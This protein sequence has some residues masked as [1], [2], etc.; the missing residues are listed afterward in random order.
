MNRRLLVFVITC[1]LSI[2]CAA[3]NGFLILSQDT[4]IDT[5]LMKQRQIHANDSTIDGYRVQI[6]MELGNDAIRHADSVREVFSKKYPDVPVYLLFGQPYYRLRVGDYRTRL[7]AENM[8]Q[9]LKKKYKNAFVTADRIELPYLALCS[10]VNYID[11]DI[12]Q[13]D[14]MRKSF[15]V[16]DDFYEIDTLLLDSLMYIDSINNLKKSIFYEE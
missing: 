1:L 13:K 6:F 9:R 8:Y 2:S 14:T 11:I 12:D 5:L 15:F 16:E 10:E 7:E 3:Q 4:R